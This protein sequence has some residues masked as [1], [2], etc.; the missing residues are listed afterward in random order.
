MNKTLAAALAACSL[1]ACA[2][3][4]WTNKEA[5]GLNAFINE[6]AVVCAPLEVGPMVVTRNFDPPDYAQGHYD[7]W[8]DETS[9]LY[10]KRITAE[11]YVENISNLGPFPGTIRAA[12]CVAA[13]AV[14]AP[15]P[16]P[17]K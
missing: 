9:R 8:F 4:A 15:P 12:K 14:G 10:Y 17:I 13:H 3:D 16:P 11:A 2:P 6:I 7:A 1:A 5:T